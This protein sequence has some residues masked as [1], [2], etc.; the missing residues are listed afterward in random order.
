MFNCSCSLIGF[1]PRVE[2]ETGHRDHREGERVAGAD[3]VEGEGPKADERH[4]PE[5]KAH[6]ITFVFVEISFFLTQALFFTFLKILR[7]SKAK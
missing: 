2:S 4:R 3:R 6:W 5:D 7:I 1:F